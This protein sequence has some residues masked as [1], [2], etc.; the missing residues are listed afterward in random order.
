[1]QMFDLNH[2]DHMDVAEGAL[3]TMFYRKM[4]ED[5]EEL[6]VEAEQEEQRRRKILYGISSEEEDGKDEAPTTGWSAC[7]WDDGE[8]E[9]DR[10]PDEWDDDADDEDEWEEDDEDGTAA[11]ADDYLSEYSYL[12][13][14]I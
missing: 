12:N 13:L 4:I 2:D 8:E 14:T 9:G 7:D 3:A 1:M 11:D 6:R 10:D 5:E